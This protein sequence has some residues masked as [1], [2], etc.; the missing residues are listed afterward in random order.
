VDLGLEGARVLVVGA[1]GGIG[2]SVVSSL[3]K[4]GATTVLA[5]S[6]PPEDEYLNDAGSPVV[7]IDL[8]DSAS[9]KAGLADAVTHL[10]ALPARQWS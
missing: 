4:E 5:S 2:S 9:I 1:R 10:G 6:N 3:D 7:R 8:R